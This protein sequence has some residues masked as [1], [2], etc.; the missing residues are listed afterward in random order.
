[1]KKQNCA[2]KLNSIV[3]FKNLFYNF[4]ANVSFSKSLNL[5]VDLTIR[6]WYYL[7]L[8]TCLNTIINLLPCRLLIE[9]DQLKVYLKMKM[10]IYKRTNN[11]M[12]FSFETALLKTLVSSNYILMAHCNTV[13]NSSRSWTQC[14]T[15][16]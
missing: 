3:L 8:L 1:M 4:I 2:I 9:H 12:I 7:L 15:D 16:L 11:K 10:N 14:C 13:P 6:H 5:S